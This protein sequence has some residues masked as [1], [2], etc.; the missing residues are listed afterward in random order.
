MD[1]DPPG[2]HA[3]EDPVRLE[4]N[5]A[6]LGHP[7]V[8]HFRWYM[9]AEGKAL[10]RKTRT[11]QASNQLVGPFKGV[12]ERNIAVDIKEILLG[13]GIDND[14][15]RSHSSTPGSAGPEK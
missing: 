11:I 3:I 5:L 13:I 2:F 15:I 4:T 1:D 10:K 7:D 6:E 8:V 9:T 14:F 12:I